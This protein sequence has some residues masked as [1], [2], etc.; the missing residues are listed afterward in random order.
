ME[1]LGIGSRIKH[2]SFGIGVVIRLNR[3]A[4]DICFIEHGIQS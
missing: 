2:P 1:L 3:K 4:Y